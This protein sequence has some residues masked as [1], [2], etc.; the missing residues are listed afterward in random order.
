MDWLQRRKYRL[1]A[2]FL[3]SL[4]SVYQWNYLLVWIMSPGRVVQTVE[5]K[6]SVGAGASRTVWALISE[7][8]QRNM[9]VAAER[10]MLVQQFSKVQ[11]SGDYQKNKLGVFVQ[12]MQ[13]WTHGRLAPFEHWQR[14]LSLANAFINSAL[15]SVT[16]HCAFCYRRLPKTMRT[17]DVGLSESLTYYKNCG[18][19]YWT[20]VSSLHQHSLYWY[21]FQFHFWR[22]FAWH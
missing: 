7:T 19:V 3:S 1:V 20:F 5:G 9:Y 18:I 12:T 16:D 13:G 15:V 21:R 14:L 17:A 8:L 6:K 2:G 22:K 10:I 11:A 4:G